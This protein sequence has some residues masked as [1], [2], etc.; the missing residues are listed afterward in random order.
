MAETRKDVTVSKGQI[1]KAPARV[2]E[3]VL[4]LTLPKI[5]HSK[6]RAIKV[7]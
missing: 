5:E 1:Q 6:R 4:E 2:M 7:D 3:G